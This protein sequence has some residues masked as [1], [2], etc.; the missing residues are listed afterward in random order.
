MEKT[1]GRIGEYV[2]LTWI[3][4]DKCKPC[5]LKIEEDAEESMKTMIFMK[6]SKAFDMIQKNE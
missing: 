6:I 5:G 4:D 3:N 1:L 2:N